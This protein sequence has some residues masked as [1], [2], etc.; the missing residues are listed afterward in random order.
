MN[1]LR[2]ARVRSRCGQTRW[3]LEELQSVPA[4]VPLGRWVVRGGESDLG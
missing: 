1:R 2:V 3:D 4:S